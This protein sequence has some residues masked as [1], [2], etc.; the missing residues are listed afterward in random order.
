MA[1]IKIAWS[2]EA[3]QDLYDILEFYL[4]RNGNANHS[5]KLSQNIFSSIQNL[6]KNPFLGRPTELQNVR[7]LI[8]SDYEIIY[9]KLDQ[10]ILIIMIWDSR[11]NPTKKDL[12][13]RKK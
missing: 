9:E 7:V 4:L 3:K 11:Q 8:K 6:I 10:V 12:V 1:K 2:I 5:K 13:Q